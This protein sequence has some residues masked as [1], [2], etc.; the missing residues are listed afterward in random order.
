MLVGAQVLHW[1]PDCDMRMSHDGL[2]ALIRKKLGVRAE[3]L[4]PGELVLCINAS[5]TVFKLVAANNFII[6]YKHP[7]GTLNYHAL[8]KLPGQ[9]LRSQR[10]NYKAA[11][12]E[13]MREWWAKEHPKLALEAKIIDVEHTARD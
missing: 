5:R 9:F 8:V 11:L 13:H 12:T 10:I 1:I 4:K 6:H 7:S 2:H 3:D